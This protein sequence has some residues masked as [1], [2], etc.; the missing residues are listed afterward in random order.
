[1][2][3][4][5]AALGVGLVVMA[6]LAGGAGTALGRPVTVTFWSHTHPPMVDLNKKLVEEFNRQNPALRVEY[7]AIPN[8]Q[9]FTK[10][11][12]AMSTGT[13]PDVLNMSSTQIARYIGSGMVAP[14]DSR[15]FGYQSQAELEQAWIPGTLAA[16]SDGGVVYGV[17]SEYNVSAMVIN[18]AHFRQAGRD[19]NAPPRTWDELVKVAEKLT[20]RQG[21]QIARRGFDFF[22]VPNFYWLDLGILLAQW[23]GDLLNA[24]GTES[25]I[26]SPQAVEAL[27]FWYDLVYQRKI[28]GPQYSLRDSTNPMADYVNEMVSMHLVYP[29]G[30]GLLD[31]TPVWKDS[32]V[33]PLPQR[34][35]RHP[36]THAYAY[37]W[38]VNAQSPNKEAAWRFVNFLASH[39]QRWLA[40]VSF[41]QPRKGWTDTPEARAFPFIDVWLDQM[42]YS[43]FLTRS[44]YWSEISAALQRAI[45]RSIMNGVA[46][47]ASL[48]QAKGEIDRALTQ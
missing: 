21:A 38:M 39:P 23:G 12:T 15:A 8:T 28:A 27:Q 19:P 16:A 9:F 7:T 20:V 22:Y 14:I 44:V 40:D 5:L 4:L 26:N 13:G 43:N 42:Q 32:R 3:R 45:E 33:V 25:T 1:M 30:I 17:P 35:P 29:W 2:K 48:D 11:L 6:L 24:Q 36:V 46:P 47:Q 31:G 41:I 18:T 37:Y 10:M 34:D